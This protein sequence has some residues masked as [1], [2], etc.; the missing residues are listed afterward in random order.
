MNTD[1]KDTSNSWRNIIVSL[2]FEKEIDID[3][4]DTSN[5]WKDNSDNNSSQKSYILDWL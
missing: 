2:Q 4:K 3:V 5:S 1:V